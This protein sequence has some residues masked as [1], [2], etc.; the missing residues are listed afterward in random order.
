M[1]YPIP[2]RQS[3]EEQERMLKPFLGQP[4]KVSVLHDSVLHQAGSE[5][6]HIPYQI[7]HS[8]KVKEGRHGGAVFVEYGRRSPSFFSFDE[9]LEVKKYEKPR[10]K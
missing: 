4:V 3:G 9:I 2:K 5:P 7:T 6:K 8:G 10:R 1:P